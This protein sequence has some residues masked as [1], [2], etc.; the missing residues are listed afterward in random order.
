MER[1]GLFRE[2]PDRAAT[3]ALAGLEVLLAQ[4]S[5]DPHRVAAIGYC[6]GGV[7]SLELAWTGANVK[8]VVGFHPGFG[9]PRLEASR[10]IRAR[11][12][13]C[14]GTE[15]PSPPGSSGRPSKRRCARPGCPIGAWSS[16]AAWGTVSPIPA[17]TRPAS[18]ASNTTPW[19]SGARGSR[20]WSCSTKPSGRSDGSA[21]GP[22][23]LRSARPRPGCGSS[24]RAAPGRR[25]RSR[26]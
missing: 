15:D 22:D 3:L 6:Y 21:P 2:D 8:V 24:S 5:T 18:R 1:L 12:L 11:V 19:P 23:R 13:M 25:P 14:C 9:P 20:C 17:P 7:M 10:H 16:T 26:S 4:P